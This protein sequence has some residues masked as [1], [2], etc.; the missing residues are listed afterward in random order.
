MKRF[1]IFA[2]TSVFLL[3]AS[4]VH[5]GATLDT[6]KKNGFIKCGVSDGLPGFSFADEKGNYSGIDVDV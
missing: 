6:I 4:N 2:V 5:A 3:A 1:K